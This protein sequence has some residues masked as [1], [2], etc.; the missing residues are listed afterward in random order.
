MGQG[1]M[2]LLAPCGGAKSC[3]LLS[4]SVTRYRD[5]YDMHYIGHRKDLGR[6]RLAACVSATIIDDL[7]CGT[8]IWLVSPRRRAHAFEQAIPR[9][10]EVISLRL[11][12]QKRRR[13]H[14]AAALLP[15]RSLIVIAHM[16][17]CY[18]AGFR[19]F[20]TSQKTE[21]WLLCH[22]VLGS[23]ALIPARRNQASS[24]LPPCFSWR[25]A[26]PA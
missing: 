15:A 6:A 13:G 7:A 10:H 23:Q 18:I 9:T 20:A 24:R 14:S 21:A 2:V 12:R 25:G 26:P 3:F 5:L 19:I 8:T 16:R 4:A 22:A 11:D 17:N 1:T